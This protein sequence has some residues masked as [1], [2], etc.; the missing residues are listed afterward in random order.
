MSLSN[1]EAN[2]AADG[3]R[4]VSVPEFSS[5]FPPDY[6][7]F[8]IESSEGVKLHIPR[9]LLMQASPIFHDM[10]ALG[11]NEEKSIVRLSEDYITLEDLLCHIDPAKTNPQFEWRTIANLLAAG[12]K[13]DIKNITDWFRNSV[14]LETFQSG[15][16][17]VEQPF[18][19]LV[20]AD[21]YQLDDIARRA[22]RQLVSCPVLELMADRVLGGHLLRHLMML[23][24]DR[25][26][27]LTKELLSLEKKYKVTFRC[28][29]HPHPFLN[30]ARPA[31]ELLAVQPSWRTI[32]Q[33]ERKRSFG[34][35]CNPKE[36]PQKWLDKLEEIEDEL[37]RLPTP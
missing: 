6:G 33:V 32:L 28:Y 9:N 13:Y 5:K 14:A 22:L 36:L 7:D 30:W 10:F 21:R 37:P 3:S 24:A 35:M 11:T 4:S 25:T 26:L 16:R 12:E 31:L 17:D 20:L 34:C 2:V 29:R 15:G 1:Q 19:C 27:T 8:I 18:L 23:R